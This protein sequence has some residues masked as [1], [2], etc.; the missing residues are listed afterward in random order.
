[1]FLNEENSTKNVGPDGHMDGEEYVFHA[2]PVPEAT[3]PGQVPIITSRIRPFRPSLTT[4]P[5]E[6]KFAT[7][8][9]IRRHHERDAE[10]APVE[11]MKVDGKRK[12]EHEHY[13]EEPE[14]TPNVLRRKMID[15][16]AEDEVQKKAK[17]MVTMPRSPMLRTRTRSTRPITSSKLRQ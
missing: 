3:K 9:R 1:M 12:R 7:E 5:I 14:F 10:R 15:G 16:N 2:Q 13:N 17:R 8:Q 6:M 4:K 11:Q